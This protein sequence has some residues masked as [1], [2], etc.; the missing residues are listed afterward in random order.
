MNLLLR[1]APQLN[2]FSMAM[3]AVAAF[4]GLAYTLLCVVGVLPWLDHTASFGE[5]AVEAA[6]IYIQ[7]MVTLVLVMFA[8]FLPTAGRVSLLERSHREFHLKMEDVAQAYY[9]CHA[10]DRSG[11]FTLSSEFDAV[12][13]RLVYLRDHPELGSLEPDVL[14]VAAQ[15]SQ[16]TR[17]LAS[18]YS[19][20][21]V[22]RA[23]L[24][25]RQRQ[26]E[27][28]AHAAQIERA[29]EACNEIKR[30]SEELH[31]ASKLTVERKSELEERL[32]TLQRDLGLSILQVE[33]N[34]LPLVPGT[35]S[36]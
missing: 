34:V 10:A 16:H 33:D 12:R 28:A 7:V 6:G 29:L 19:D 22:Q 2:Y 35:A 18:I 27:V 36:N 25:L 20:E 1:I 4:S 17:E 24:F 8:S 31:E 23:T 9:H 14:E 5:T 32:R 30:W 3:V 11:I 21:N 15:M 26:E 13:E